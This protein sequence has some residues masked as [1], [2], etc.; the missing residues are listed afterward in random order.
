MLRQLRASFQE[1]APEE[2]FAE[3]TSQNTRTIS[4]KMPIPDRHPASVTRFAHKEDY[5]TPEHAQK[6]KEEANLFVRIAAQTKKHQD[7]FAVL[8]DNVFP[9]LP[10]APFTRFE[11]P[12]IS[13]TGGPGRSML[14]SS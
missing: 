9:V 6:R 2:V 1:F 3:P 4:P 14:M 11:S 8:Q 13:P 5:G 7:V 12:R 10:T